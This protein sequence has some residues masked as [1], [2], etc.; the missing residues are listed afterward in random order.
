MCL[1][2]CA[3]ACVQEKAVK[4]K[5]TRQIFMRI[6]EPPGKI[7]RRSRPVRCGRLARHHT[8]VERLHLFPRGSNGAFLPPAVSTDRAA[9]EIDPIV[10]F[11]ERLKS[12]GVGEAALDA[13]DAFT[14][15]AVGAAL[16]TR[17]AFATPAA[18]RGVVAATTGES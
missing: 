14:T 15:A 10:W 5:A 9:T 11:A 13:W 16:T 7:S 3:A 4:R 1:T 18:A 2:D 6:F 8:L 17:S 12:L